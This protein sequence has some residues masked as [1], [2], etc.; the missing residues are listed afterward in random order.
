MLKIQDE[1]RNFAELLRERGRGSNIVEAD[2][3]FRIA[4]LLTDQAK[5]VAEAE[6]IADALDE[7]E[8]EEKQRSNKEELARLQV[9]IDI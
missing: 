3:C 4:E 7:L 2:A 6:L 8:Y 1:L 5:R 9:W